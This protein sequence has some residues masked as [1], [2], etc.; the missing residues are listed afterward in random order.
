[1]PFD[2]L[3]RRGTRPLWEL[4]SQEYE[5]C[6]SE[7][8]TQL[9]ELTKE[10]LFR[11]AV[12]MSNPQ[13]HGFLDGWRGGLDAGKRRRK[14]R[15]R[16]RTLYRFL[17]RFTAKNDTTS[18]FGATSL[19]RLDVQRTGPLDLPVADIR[20]AFLE[21]WAAQV[22][23]EVSA[24][25]LDVEIPEG[26]IPVGHPRV[27]DFLAGWLEAQPR[28]PDRLRWEER[29]TNL[30]S[31]FVS[32]EKASYVER[33]SIFR[34]IEEDF[35]AWT[36]VQTRRGEGKYYSSKTV[37]HEVGDRSGEVIGLVA[38]ERSL[39]ENALSPVMDFCALPVLVERIKTQAYLETKLG[40]GRV[41]LSELMDALASS[42]TDYHLNAPL[43]ARHLYGELKE[44][45]SHMRSRIDAQV[46]DKPGEAVELL[47]AK[48]QDF[49]ERWQ[50]AL[51][52]SGRA[53][54]NPDILL[55]GCEKPTL[56][57]GDMHA[58][59][60]LTPA[61]FAAAPRE[62]EAWEDTRGFL[63]DLCH[64]EV[65]AFLT[66]QRASFVAYVPDLGEV[67]LEIDGRASVPEE[68]RCDFANVTVEVASGRCVFKVITRGGDEIPVMP[69]TRAANVMS[70]YSQV[71]QRTARVY[72]IKLLE[73][74]RWLAG[75]GWR[76]VG[77]LPRLCFGGVVVHRRAWEVC[78]QDWVANNADP[79][80]SFIKLGALT[81]GELP[82]FCYVKG[83]DDPKPLLVDFADPMSAEL[84]LWMAR[85]EP[86]LSL[87]EMLP[88]A[89]SLW[90]KGPGGN[91][92]SELRTVYVR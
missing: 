89:D 1:M 37:L 88:D 50:S 38:E 31:R 4:S 92:T 65:P 73:L 29:F 21:H 7:A 74:G 26:G 63:S 8:R 78:S 25:D 13:V 34:A 10:P 15:K 9:W 91:Y 72:P 35:R 19:G 71:L 79:H 18:F 55:T 49:I 20:R 54:T 48:V 87:T 11:E 51:K 61:A 44:I 32:F 23:L 59:P 24:G 76:Q 30:R 22:L 56:V 67:A 47:D 52:K 36:Q 80:A 70:R 64:P 90:L 81:D 68:R 40:S 60:F 85:N 46:K 45:R 33:L 66:H 17:T 16:E 77:E 82:R 83:G 69:L 58:M 5:T 12:F 39:M 86:N 41:P 84:F 53:Y 43:E 2:W 27:F 3:L 28:S 14:D 6:L 57:L 62:E 42:G 75:P